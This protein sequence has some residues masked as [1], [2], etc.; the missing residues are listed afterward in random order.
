MGGRLVT[1][2]RMA[3]LS[4]A[5]PPGATQALWE[6]RLMAEARGADV[7]QGGTTHPACRKSS[8]TMER[9]HQPL[10]GTPSSMPHPRVPRP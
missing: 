4:P 8:R 2:P 6:E 1:A 9:E 5:H 7:P 3:D 10:V